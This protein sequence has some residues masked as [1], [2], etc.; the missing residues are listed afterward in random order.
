MKRLLT[1][2]ATSLCISLFT[3]SAH[4]AKFITIGTGGVTG[5]YYPS[6][7]AIAKMV[8]AKRK[9]Y[10]IRATVES[11]GGSVM[12]VNAILA[13][14]LELGIVQSDRG[15]QAWNGLAEWEKSGPQKS[16][17]SVFSLHPELVN[18][19][20]AVDSGA[21][22]CKSLKGKRIAVGNPG[23]GTRQNAEDALQTCGLTFDD[24]KK[25]DFKASEGASMLK[26]GR[27]D[28][29]FYTVGHPNGSIKEA[30]AG[31]RDLAFVGFERNE[32]I[33]ALPYYVAA[34]VPLESY[35]G[36][37][38]ETKVTTFGVKA[39]LLSSIEVSEEAIYAITREVFENIDEFKQLHPAFAY[40]TK[41]SMLEG[42]TAPIHPGAEKY[43][44]E[45]G[46]IK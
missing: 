18:L 16:L 33:K 42:L 4:A 21:K 10:G 35:A 7:G 45:V 9:E 24:I 2:L 6:G 20:V 37:M 39:T 46:L 25:E 30:I 12:N 22:D 17:R 34:D 38:N 32:K 3:F 23:S 5:V 28:G 26:D 29:Y 15:Y 27:I 41:E 13:G 31:K 14:D 44:R 8:N 19:I 43:Y 1:I 11:T 36:I 40:L